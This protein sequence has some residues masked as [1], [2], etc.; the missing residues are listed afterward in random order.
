[1]P[2]SSFA[3]CFL[4]TVPQKPLSGGQSHPCSHRGGNTLSWALCFAAHATCARSARVDYRGAEVTSENLLR[5][6][7]DRH[8][9]GVRQ[10]CPRPPACARTALKTLALCENRK[11]A[12]RTRGA[13]SPARPR[14][15]FRTHFALCLSW[16]ATCHRNQQILVI[17]NR[18]HDAESGFAVCSPHCHTSFPRGG[19]SHPYSRRLSRVAADGRAPAPAQRCWE[20]RAA[21]HHGSVRLACP[22]LI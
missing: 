20:P 12:C 2:I 7:S 16:H 3:V 5:V 18:R 11:I 13:P 9:P 22:D 10:Q 19:Q 4:S 15:R 21:L 14:S 6:L 8:P 1:M 17:R